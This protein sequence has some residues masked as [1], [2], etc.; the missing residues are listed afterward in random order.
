MRDTFLTLSCFVSLSSL[1]CF[2]SLISSIFFSLTHFF[3][4]FFLPLPI[5]SYQSLSLLLLSF[6]FACINLPLILITSSFFHSYCLSFSLS[7]FT[8]FS[9]FLWLLVS[10]SLYYFPLACS[11]LPFTR[12]S[13][14]LIFLLF[15]FIFLVRF[16]YIFLSCFLPLSYSLP[17][18]LSWFLPIF[19]PSSFLSCLHVSLLLYLFFHFFYLRPFTLCLFPPSLSFSYF[20]P[21]ILAS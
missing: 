17:C 4:S 16:A 1:S 11:Q 18:F 9:F 13:F 21:Y 14:F 3:L 15:P 2:V 8:Y 5:V 6:L 7:P 20:L 10:L 12:T 19:S